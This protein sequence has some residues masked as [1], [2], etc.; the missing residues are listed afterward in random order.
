M[1]THPLARA[2]RIDKLCL[3]A[4][5]ATLKLYLEPKTA[6]DKIPI[7]RMLCSTP[8]AMYEKAVRLKDIL[9]KSN[10][11]AEISVITETSQVGG[12]AMPGENFTTAAVAIKTDMPAQALEYHFRSGPIPIIGRISHNRFILDVRTIDENDFLFIAARL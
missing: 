11:H 7:L 3:A 1:K 5:E 2:M 10:K 8:A 6:V 12:G 4:L 9:E